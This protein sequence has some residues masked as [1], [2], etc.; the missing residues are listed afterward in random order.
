MESG[1]RSGEEA[2]CDAAAAAGQCAR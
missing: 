2:R 1:E